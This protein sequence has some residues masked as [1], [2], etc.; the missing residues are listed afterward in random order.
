MVNTYLV[1]LGYKNSHHV[2][3]ISWDV[4]LEDL[5]LNLSLVTYGSRDLLSLLRVF[6]LVVPCK[7]ITDKGP[8]QMA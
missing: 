8:G 3:P 6:D 7:S 2:V 5:S 1:S 4:P